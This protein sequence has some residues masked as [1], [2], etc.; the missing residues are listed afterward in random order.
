MNREADV[1]IITCFSA[2][3]NGAGESFLRNKIDFRI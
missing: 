3:C 2:D 1:F